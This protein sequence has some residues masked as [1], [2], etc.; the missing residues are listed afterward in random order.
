MANHSKQFKEDAVQ[1][2]K[3]NKDLGLKGCAT[4]LGY[5]TALNQFHLSCII[6]VI[7]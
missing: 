1:Y 3:D 4:N 5:A 6:Q 2:Y 7:V